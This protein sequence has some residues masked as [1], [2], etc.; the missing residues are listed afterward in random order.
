MTEPTAEPA[1]TEPDTAST[2]L[3]VSW[4]V[5]GIPLLY[6]LYMTIKS[7]LPLFGG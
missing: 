1:T 5:V 3:V 2:R 6:G 7:V 4:L